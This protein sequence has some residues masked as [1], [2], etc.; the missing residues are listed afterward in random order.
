MKGNLFLATA[1]LFFIACSNGSQNSGTE[2]PDSLSAPS[3][4]LIEEV[5]EARMV[6]GFVGTGTSMNV[7]ELVSTEATDTTWIELDDQTVRDATL[8]VG[9]EISAVVVENSDGSLR[10]LATMDVELGQ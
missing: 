5:L 3:D 8:E 10:A 7:I 6:K 9:Q 4:S 2:S 1:T